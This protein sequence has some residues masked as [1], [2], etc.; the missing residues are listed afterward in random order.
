ML[1]D[2][3]LRNML[4]DTGIDLHEAIAK[5]LQNYW[6]EREY[7]KFHSKLHPVVGDRCFTITQS[8]LE[9]PVLITTVA[10]GTAK[11]DG[12]S[13]VLPGHLP[14]TICSGS[15]GR[16]LGELIKT[17]HAILERRSVSH[18]VNDEGY[19]ADYE[20]Y[21]VTIISLGPDLIEIGAPER[22]PH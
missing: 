10:I 12:A 16:R 17:G 20:P 7:V 22:P 21:P 14:D 8:G 3:Q 5:R 18:V 1:I 19:G 15:A 13:L 4:E 2:R 11:Y 9:T 6:W